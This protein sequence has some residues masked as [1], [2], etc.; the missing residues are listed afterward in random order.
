MLHAIPGLKLV[1]LTG[2]ERCCGGAGVYNLLEPE[3]SGEVL[4]EKLGHI[5]T[6]APRLPR[7]IPAATCK[8]GA[9][10]M[11]AG[12]HAARLSPGRASR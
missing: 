3:L 6:P 11:L 10:A 7:G 5:P 12:L 8:I 4:N 2:S 1:P 9:G